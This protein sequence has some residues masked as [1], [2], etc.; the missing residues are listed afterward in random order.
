MA[1]VGMRL[2]ADGLSLLEWQLAL[3]ALQTYLSFL[4][5]VA[6]GSASLGWCATAASS[7]NK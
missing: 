3:T 6:N 2:D 4:R 1:P 5:K 7:M